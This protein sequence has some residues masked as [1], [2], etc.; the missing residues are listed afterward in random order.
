MKIRVDEFALSAW[1]SHFGDIVARS[2]ELG[3]RLFS[4][5]EGQFGGEIL[6]SLVNMA[7][8][9]DEKHFSSD[10]KLK[11]YYK[12]P[13]Y[14]QDRIYTAPMVTLVAYRP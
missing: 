12:Y 14:I 4:Q 13:K 6:I 2:V 5:Y 11:V 7:S 9:F 10:A 3:Q 8:D 1:E